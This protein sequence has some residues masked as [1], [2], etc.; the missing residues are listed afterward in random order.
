MPRRLLWLGLVAGALACASMAHAAVIQEGNLRIT[1]TS[2][3]QPYK[4][5]RDKAA[6][7]AVFVAGH[8]QAPHGGIPAQLQRMTVKFNRHGL[9]QSKGL[10]L[11]PIARLQPASTERA[12]ANCGDALIGSGQFW[13]HIVFPDQGTYGTRGRLLIFN[14]KE[15]G[16]PVLL[17]HIFTSNPFFSSF[18]L[19][20][21]IKKIEGT[22][23]T[24]LSASLPEALGSWGYVDRIKLTL[25]RKYTYRG[26]QL[27]YF[28]SA[29]PA[30][31]GVKRVVFPLAQAS[32][33]FAEGLDLTTRVDKSCAVSE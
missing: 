11:C 18:V 26:K 5:P 6:P 30:P 33:R 14:G 16:R 7:I 19:T 12:L 9:L 13:A 4:L 31:K 17:V 10:A 8:L 23:G 2:Q 28:N 25:K 1:I 21:A 24:E 22:Y 29:C 32:F 15:A 3:I 27:S 20:F